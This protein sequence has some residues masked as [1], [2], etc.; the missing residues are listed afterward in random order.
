MSAGRDQA[1]VADPTSRWPVP[2][3]RVAMRA[4]VGAVVLAACGALL[5]VTSMDGHA[6]AAGLAIF[7][8]ALGVLVAALIADR[9]RFR[10]LMAVGAWATVLVTCLALVLLAIDRSGRGAAA[11]RLLEATAGVLGVIGAW[12]IGCGLALVARAPSWPVRIAQ[13]LAVAMGTV[14]SAFLMALAV[15]PDTIKWM[16]RAVGTDAFERGL[17]TVLVTGLGA[18]I[19][20]PILIRLTRVAVDDQASA[21]GGRRV[22][23]D[24]RCPRCG[25]ACSIR[26]NVD[27]SCAGCSLALRVELAEPRCRCGYLLHAL[28]APRCPEC[29]DPVPDGSRWPSVTTSPEPPSP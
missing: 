18:L 24:L 26:S 27:E 11:P 4:F 23:V 3:V 17:A 16:A 15:A 28:E 21:L 25:T 5:T 6:L 12:S 14:G 20:Q 10:P 8:G 29:G 1:V 19:V 13:W 7:G 22:L 2:P 9:G